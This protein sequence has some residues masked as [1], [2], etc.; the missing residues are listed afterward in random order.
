MIVI[1]LLHYPG[2]GLAQLENGTGKFK[3]HI[4]CPI[5]KISANTCTEVLICAIFKCGFRIA[6][7][8]R[9]I[10]LYRLHHHIEYAWHLKGSFII[11]YS[12]LVW[13]VKEV[14]TCN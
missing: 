13:D 5:H 2:F 10:E 12:L 7:Y 1:T 14:V 4:K 3:I 8:C 6:L 11:E 9:A